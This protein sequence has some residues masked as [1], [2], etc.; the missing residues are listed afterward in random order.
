ML[1]GVSGG[2]LAGATKGDQRGLASRRAWAL[3][4]H[5]K[6]RLSGNSDAP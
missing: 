6:A 2:T 1:D 3:H 4:E 5:E